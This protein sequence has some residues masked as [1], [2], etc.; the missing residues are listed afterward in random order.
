M[1][2]ISAR[3]LALAFAVSGLAISRAPAAGDAEQAANDPSVRSTAPSLLPL[4]EMT[5]SWATGDAYPMAR[6]TNYASLAPA[7]DSGY[8]RRA[9]MTTWYQAS[10]TPPP[11]RPDGGHD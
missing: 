8:G 4:P 7:V 1:K 3:T 5:S 2:M 10:P 6:S 9:A 11:A